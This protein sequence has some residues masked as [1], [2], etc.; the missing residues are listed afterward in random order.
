M[1]LLV[2]SIGYNHDTK[3]GVNSA[4]GIQST[5]VSQIRGDTYNDTTLTNG[6]H[7]WT[8]GLEPWIKASN[9]TFVPYILSQNATH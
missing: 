5:I 4:F 9:G 8:G 1:I 6:Q 2:L 3:V 7:V